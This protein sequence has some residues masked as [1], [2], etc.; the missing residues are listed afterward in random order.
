MPLDQLAS[1]WPELV[2]N[3]VGVLLGGIGALALARWQLR[4][5][6]SEERERNREHLK[7]VL[8][9]V[10]LEQNENEELIEEIRRVFQRDRA[11]RPDLLRWAATIAQ[12]L[13]L[14]AHAE[15][16]RG[17]HHR[18]LPAEVERQ[19]FRAYHATSTLRNALRQ[20]E[21]AVQFYVACCGEEEAAQRL[22]GEL[23]ERIETAHSEVAGS[24]ALIEGLDVVETRS[25]MPALAPAAPSG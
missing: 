21:P 15:L 22:V 20:A 7:A 10:R 19:V 23:E 11:A 17:G 6:S 25:A 13:T 14:D 2:A 9:W 3:T 12:A 16:V 5:Q 4:R 8:D 18:R 1:L 24:W